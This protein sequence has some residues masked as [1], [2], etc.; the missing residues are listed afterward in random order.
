[1]EPCSPT[2]RRTPC[3]GLC[4]APTGAPQGSTP[5]PPPHTQ[6]PRGQVE[7]WKAQCGESRTL[8]LGGGKGRKPSP[9]RTMVRTEKDEERE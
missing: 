1:M 3:N 4:C 5:N 8:R 6:G 7:Y 9:I 2:E